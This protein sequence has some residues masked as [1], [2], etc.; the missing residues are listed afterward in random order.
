MRRLQCIVRGGT[1][2]GAP[3]RDQKDEG[4]KKYRSDQARSASAAGSKETMKGSGKGG[5][6]TE[7]DVEAAVINAKKKW[8]N[9][10]KVRRQADETV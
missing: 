1:K 5:L 10:L 9:A 7:A 3:L 4:H 8:E 2:I 6:V